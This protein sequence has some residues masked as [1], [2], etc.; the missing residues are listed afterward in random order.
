MKRSI[1]HIILF[2]LL[3]DF[4]FIN[5]QD[6]KFFSIHREQSQYYQNLGPLSVKQY[7]SIN[8]FSGKISQLP[9]NECVLEKIVF[10]YHP[11]WMGSNYLNYQWNLLSDLCY[12]SY[13]VDPYTGDPITTHNWLTADA[14]DS[15]QANG[16]RTHLCVTL[17]S[18]H[19]TFLNNIHV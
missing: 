3:V 13:E 11:Y 7:D 5:A 8:Q 19:S 6:Q 16:V 17:F 4:G 9:V 14:V 15:A 12:F 1:H 2:L 10:G 18:N